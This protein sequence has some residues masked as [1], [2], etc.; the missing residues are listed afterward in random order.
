MIQTKP[1]SGDRG[2]TGT[3]SSLP[4]KP[5][6]QHGPAFPRA[7]SIACLPV[8]KARQLI[9]RSVLKRANT[10]EQNSTN[11][12]A[13]Q[14]APNEKPSSKVAARWF[15]E[16]HETKIFSQS[17]HTGNSTTCF[18]PL[19]NFGPSDTKTTDAAPDMR[20]APMFL[21]RL[22]LTLTNL[23]PQGS[24]TLQKPQQA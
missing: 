2:G 10:E 13:H 8:A 7:C 20:T 1:P 19:L 17:V 16:C 15:P 12:S 23:T 14:R 4:L 11:S 5:Q 18:S 6:S 3:P 24:E 9:Y 21:M 22:W